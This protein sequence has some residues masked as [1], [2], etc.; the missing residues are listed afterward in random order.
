[1]AGQEGID[2]A[3]LV[4]PALR[5]S[6]RIPDPVSDRVPDAAPEARRIDVGEAD[7]DAPERGHPVEV[8]EEAILRHPSAGRVHDAAN[9]ARRA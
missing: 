1:M 8:P 2:F 6:D 7:R 5:T 4:R 3:V 9:E